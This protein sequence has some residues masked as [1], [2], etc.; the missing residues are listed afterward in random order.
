MKIRDL[1]EEIC[2]DLGHPEAT[3]HVLKILCI[4]N[5]LME[6]TD[7]EHVPDKTLIAW[8]LPFMLVCA[9]RSR[10]E[11]IA[12]KKV[13]SQR[14]GVIN[15][16]ILPAIQSGPAMKAYNWAW[17]QIDK[18]M[19]SEDWAAR[20]LQGWWRCR[21]AETLGFD[22]AEIHTE[23]G[24][25]M[26]LAGRIKAV[27]E[28]EAKGKM[29][30]M[31]PFWRNKKK[32]SHASVSKKYE[33]EGDSLSILGI[34]ATASTSL[35]RW[36]QDQIARDWRAHQDE[37]VDCEV[38]TLIEDIVEEIAPEGANPTPHIHRLVTLNWIE[39]IPDLIPI[40]DH[41]WDQW[42]LPHGLV[43]EL[44]IAVQNVVQHH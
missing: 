30:V 37:P 42:E 8:G 35:G 16:T 17:D 27:Q 10:S 26:T 5:W 1:I 44:K 14:N 40:S 41:F 18:S 4:K 36:M 28:N 39:Q 32:R 34:K 25:Y 11:E 38:K 20:K 43:A 22:L 3:K 19:N 2:D 15:Y 31:V 6:A 33:E 9:I 24:G 23:G 12:S 7:L 29:S 13:R 21:K